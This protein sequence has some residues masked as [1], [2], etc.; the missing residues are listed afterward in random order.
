M[1]NRDNTAGFRGKIN[2]L[3]DIKMSP[4]EEKKEDQGEQSHE[5]QGRAEY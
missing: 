5:I 1:E 3:G 2:N 4:P